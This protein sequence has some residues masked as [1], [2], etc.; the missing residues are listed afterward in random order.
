MGVLPDRLLK[1]WCSPRR[2]LRSSH[3]GIAVNRQSVRPGV[4]LNTNKRTSFGAILDVFPIIPYTN[5][6]SVLMDGGSRLVVTLRVGRSQRLNPL[7]V[8]R[9]VGRKGS[10]QRS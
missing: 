4:A 2:A 8:V 10:R 3:V 5:R 7:R 9:R 1:L 6:S